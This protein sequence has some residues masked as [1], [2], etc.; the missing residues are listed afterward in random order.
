MTKITDETNLHGY[1]RMEETEDRKYSMDYY[2]PK[3][4]NTNNFNF[5]LHPRFNQGVLYETISYDKNMMIHYYV[6]VPK[7]LWYN[8]DG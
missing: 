8:Y 4:S 3:S 1:G 2:I 7:G 5:T 6:P